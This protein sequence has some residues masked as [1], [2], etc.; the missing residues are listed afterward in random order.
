MVSKLLKLSGG[1][2]KHEHLNILYITENYC[3]SYYGKAFPDAGA[4]DYIARPF[5]PGILKGKVESVINEYLQRKRLEEELEQRKII[6]KELKKRRN[7]W[8]KRS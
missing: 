3:E 7:G 8:K 5:I 2:K 4:V 1:E 6:E